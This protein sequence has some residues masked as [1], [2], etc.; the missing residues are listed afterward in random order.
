M[1]NWTLCQGARLARALRDEDVP[2]VLGPC[3]GIVLGRA[4]S[5][6]IVFFDN[7]RGRSR[8]GRAVGAFFFQPKVTQN[9]NTAPHFLF[10]FIYLLP[11]RL[12]VCDTS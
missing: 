6:F 1:R 4:L 3:Q 10:E 11:A 8:T 12:F 2:G 7:Y 9:C 5:P